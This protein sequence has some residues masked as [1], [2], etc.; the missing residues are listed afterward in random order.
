M[1]KSE[2]FKSAHKLTKSVIKAGDNYQITFGASIKVILS[3]FVANTEVYVITT[4]NNWTGFTSTKEVEAT[5]HKDA[6]EKF[7][8]SSRA[9]VESVSKKVGTLVEEIEDAENILFEMDVKGVDSMKFKG[10][11][12]MIT[13]TRAK[14]EAYLAYRN[15]SKS[16]SRRQAL[17]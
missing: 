14:V 1:N 17:A 6:V 8:A 16:M 2:L 12:N 13:V 9:K 11:R 7:E 15:S 3:G 10:S 4:Y 5:S